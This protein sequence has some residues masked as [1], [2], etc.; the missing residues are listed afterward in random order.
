[1]KEAMREQL[2]FQVFLDKEVNKVKGI[3][4][5]VKA[6]FL[7]RVLIRKALCRKLHPNP[8]DEFCFPEIGP[9]YQIISGYEKDYRII[10]RNASRKHTMTGGIAEPIMVE[11]VHPDGYMILNGHHRWAAALHTGIRSLSVRIVDLTQEKDIREMLQ[12]GSFDRRAALDLDEVVF[13][14]TDDPYTEKALP[15]PLNRIY[16]ERIRLGVPAL[17]HTLHN[18]GCDIWVYTSQY[19]SLG[20]L[21]YY[22]KHYRVPVTGIVTGTARKAPRGSDTMKE[23]NRMLDT[24]YSSTIHIDRDMILCTSG[25]SREFEEYRLS[26]SPETWSREVIGILEKRKPHE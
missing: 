22:F 8:D 26:G 14:S 7:R 16:R 10:K 6:G 25:D 21:R 19:Y 20:Y 1:M 3:Y 13:C 12:A 23:L 9:N 2:D 11:K 5:P 17:F 15:F 24:K 4:Y 18:N